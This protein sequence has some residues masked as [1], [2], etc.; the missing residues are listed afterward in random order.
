MKNVEI[1]RIDLFKKECRPAKDWV[2]EEK[3]LHLFLDG[4][5]YASIHCSPSNLEELA[6]GHL[7]SEGILK[8]VSE[9]ETANVRDDVCRVKFIPGIDAKRRLRLSKQFGRVILSACGVQ[10]SYR[11][12]RKLPKIKSTLKVQANTILDCVKELNS[13]PVFRKT[14]GVHAAAIF[15]GDGTRVAFAEDI[16]RHNAVDKVVGMAMTCGTDLRNCFI[17][18]TGRL[19]GDMVM[20][21]ATV[22]S[23]I[24]ASV[25]AAI[26][27]GIAIAK[28][29][30]LTLVGFVRGT[31][32]NV[33]TCPE[34]IIL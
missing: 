33:Y 34:R 6:I 8:S 22:K 14:G 9:I 3:P 17:V 11:L 18:S 12:S 26:D 30:N 7:A 21:A 31:H 32:M 10:G 5:S 2:A 13:A 1:V 24:V 4:S 28:R 23:P 27:S 29:V 20:K 19:T 16:G 15:E 25:A